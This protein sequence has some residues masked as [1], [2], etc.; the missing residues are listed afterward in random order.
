MYDEY[1]DPVVDVQ[2]AARPRAAFGFL[3]EFSPVQRFIF[4]VL[5]FFNVV[6]VGFAF[7]VFM[8]CMVL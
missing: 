3:D 2:R 6:I 7:L 5:L 8:G 4:S 1:P